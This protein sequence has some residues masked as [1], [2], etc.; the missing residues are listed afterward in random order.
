MTENENRIA[1]A[2]S[3]FWLGEADQVAAAYNLGEI[4]VGITPETEVAIVGTR[5]FEFDELAHLKGVVRLGVGYDN[6]PLEQLRAAGIVA[7]YTPYAPTASVAELALLLILM[8]IRAGADRQTLRRSM[9]DCRL[10]VVGCGRIGRALIAEAGG[11]FREVRVVDPMPPDHVDNLYGVG[12]RY[13]PSQLLTALSWADVVSLHC[14][15]EPATRHMIGWDELAAMKADAV[16]INT[17]RGGIVN[18][19]A[20]ATHLADHAEFRV[21]LDVSEAEPDRPAFSADPRVIW[22]GHTA[23]M[24]Y[25]ARRR[26]ER[27]AVAAAV[28]II[29]GSIPESLIPEEEPWHKIAGS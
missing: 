3:G 23:S 6:L 7:A 9:R 27:D 29:T 8:H 10:L 14:P 22:T 11:R 17:A 28:D 19:A 16:L 18:E 12:A 2:T 20:L 13:K 4:G 26:M 1:R 24:T 21:A 5:P 25:Q 15:L